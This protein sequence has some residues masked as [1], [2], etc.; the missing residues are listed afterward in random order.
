[1]NHARKE[2]ARG[3][4]TLIELLVVIAIIAL[5]IGL[6]LP[7]LAK[8]QRNARSMKDQ[9]QIKQIH[10]AMLI[11][12]NS[13]QER[14]PLPGLINRLPWSAQAGPATG[15]IPGLGRED[16]FKNHTRHLYSAMIAAELFNT[17]LVIG[18]T[19]ISK[20]VV[21]R[22]NY[23]YA[24]INPAAD[25]YW[26]G[27]AE[28]TQN[29]QGAGATTDPNV[30]NCRIDGTGG[31]RSHSSYAHMHLCGNRKKTKW[32]NTQN[33]GDPMVGT[34]GTG[35]DWGTPPSH[36]GALTGDQFT[37]SITL[38]LHGDKNRWV[39]NVVFNDNHTESLDNFF[40]AVTFYVPNAIGMAGSP[41]QD[42]IFAA[43]FGTVEP[44]IA[45]EGRLA[46]DAWIGFSESITGTQLGT[47]V[48]TAIFD[49]L[50]P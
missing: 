5:L 43:E 6:L 2:T 8:A 28:S 35:G 34:R 29:G 24:A 30:F 15:N 10:Q 42:N 46:A 38:Y 3:G 1:M 7:A 21:Q 44:D 19:E 32:R 33:A 20:H 14:L 39:G 49:E 50:L 47:G 48:T 27:D 37:K 22:T 31:L 13:N 17:D 25:S 26:D 4:F 23:N 18:P 40:P 12:A 16:T 45:G 36:G 9:T 41:Q 11:W